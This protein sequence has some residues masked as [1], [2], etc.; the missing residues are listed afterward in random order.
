MAT[1]TKCLHNISHVAAAA[2]EISRQSGEKGSRIAET[3]ADGIISAY[4]NKHLGIPESRRR[5]EAKPDFDLFYS[6]VKVLARLMPKGG[7]PSEI[8][9][10]VVY[11]LS[12]SECDQL[13]K[14]I[15]TSPNYYRV[16]ELLKKTE[17]SFAMN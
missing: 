17:L 11:L 3:R 1:I 13:K 9:K 7:V 6:R 8:A 14:S 15:R 16:Q 12:R 5:H 10:I 4:V 2:S